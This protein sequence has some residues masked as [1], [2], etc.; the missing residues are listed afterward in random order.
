MHVQS[1]MFD[2]CL[3]MFTRVVSGFRSLTIA[4]LYLQQ[5]HDS[6]EDL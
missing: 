4:T 6:D 5:L 2:K 1:I 3:V